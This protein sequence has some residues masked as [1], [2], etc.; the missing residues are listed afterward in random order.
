MPVCPRCQ[1]LA[2][3]LSGGY[4]PPCRSEVSREWAIKNKDRLLAKQ[5]E[6]YRRNP[7]QDKAHRKAYRIREKTDA[8]AAYGGKCACCGETEPDF[9][10][11]DHVGGGG[12]AHRENANGVGKRFYAWLRRNGYPQ[13]GLRVLCNNCNMSIGLYGYCPH[14][15]ERQQSNLY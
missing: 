1:N 13:D 4:C 3:K 14:E 7:E 15:R 2:A 11:I 12:K 8:I 10:A 9:L 6:R 5:R